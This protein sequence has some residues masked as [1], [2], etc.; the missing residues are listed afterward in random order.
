MAIGNLHCL[1]RIFIVPCILVQADIGD[2]NA[3]LQYQLQQCFSGSTSLLHG[4]IQQ[5][6]CLKSDPFRCL[7]HHD[8]NNRQYVALKM[9]CGV[10][11]SGQQL[12]SYTWH[13]TVPSKYGLYVD[14]LHFHLPA[15]PHCKSVAAV[16]VLHAKSIS[17]QL[18]YTYCGYRMPWYIS[19]PQSFVRVQCINEYNTPKG[20]HFVM[21]FQAFDI[22]STSVALTQWNEQELYSQS[23]ILPYLS[24]GKHLTFGETEIQLHIIV[25]VYNKIRL[26]YSPDVLIKLKIYDGPG[27]L[28]PEIDS[29]NKSYITFSSYQGFV[30]YAIRTIDNIVTAYTFTNNQSY[31]NTSLLNWISAHNENNYNRSRHD[32]ILMNQNCPLNKNNESE[33]LNLQG[34]SGRCW[35]RYKLHGIIT[36]NQLTYTGVNMLRHSPSNRSPT[37][38]YGGLFV[39]MYHGNS[40]ISDPSLS[41]IRI[42]SNVT[43]KI[44]LPINSTNQEYLENYRLKYRVGVIFI[45]F[46]GYSSGYVDLTITIDQECF[47]QNMLISRGPSCN[48]YIYFWTDKK[49]HRIQREITY[50]TDVWLLND[51]DIFESSPF[52][53]CT[54]T[55]DHAQLGFPVNAYKMITYSS[56]IHQSTTYVDFDGINLLSM[57]VD[58]LTYI[59]IETSLITDNITFSVP[60]L[61]QSEYIFNYSSYTDFKI[62][63]S[64]YDQFPKF[65]IRVQFIENRICSPGYVLPANGDDSD[66][67]LYSSNIVYKIE[68][69]SDVYINPHY[70]FDEFLPFIRHSGYNRG[71]CRTLVVGSTCS[72]AS[73]NEIIRIHYSPHKSLTVPHEVDISMK[74]TMNCSIKCSLN[75]GILE[76]ID[77][78]NT[79]TI[80]YHEWRATYR[81]TWQ[82][83]AA[84]SRGFSIT[85]NSTCDACTPTCN[86]AIALGLPINSHKMF[87]PNNIDSKY[88]NNFVAEFSKTYKTFPATYATYLDQIG[89]YHR[90]VFQW[91]SKPVSF[92]D[93]QSIL[94]NFASL[95]KKIISPDLVHGNW[96]DAHAYCEER[97]STLFALQPS[98]SGH[99]LDLV[100]SLNHGWKNSSDY[101]FAGLHHVSSVCILIK[102]ILYHIS[103]N[104]CLL[105]NKCLPQIN[106]YVRTIV[107]LINASPEQAPPP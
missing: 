7:L 95:P 54:F 22:E 26:E 87:N 61:N 85:I 21:T 9:M 45:T 50:C 62:S 10:L 57:D 76:Y 48:N 106:T 72:L 51:I 49:F 84:K 34:V 38:Q 12:I 56:L 74:K 80:R 17:D 102:H 16:S 41:Y 37:C 88:L 100:T 27:C 35:L 63:F 19:F 79:R 92:N 107:I 75:I 29:R 31:I 24:L 4:I 52:E 1:I 86:I 40:N 64:G 32:E 93:F 8:P 44:I 78:N 67:Y 36:I 53:N 42:C 73:S 28:S 14:F 68:N 104:R 30:K 6:A 66:L 69:I 105:S 55:L 77:G 81:L 43:D 25:M 33:S 3:G 39:V 13:I 20:F 15:S 11:N 70:L 101:Y 90:K 2:V 98:M 82:V 89:W 47:G 5:F 65:A 18:I 99:L 96:Y 83:I 60:V 71:V 58:I 46:Q 59:D 103:S 23:F 97:N 91:I 94:E